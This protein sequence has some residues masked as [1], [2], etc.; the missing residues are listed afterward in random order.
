LTAFR[1]IQ[2]N[3][4]EIGPLRI[5]RI[6]LERNNGIMMGF[7]RFKEEA[8]ETLVP[9]TSEGIQMNKEQTNFL[10]YISHKK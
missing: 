1:I 10:L 3:I 9:L 6:P 5:M 8:L 2:S 7:R 4:A